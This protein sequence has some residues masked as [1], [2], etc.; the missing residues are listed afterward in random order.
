MGRKGKVQIHTAKEIKGKVQAAK[1][2]NGAAGGGGEGAKNRVEA[3]AKASVPCEVCTQ[4]LPSL[5]TAKI[6]FE[7]KHPKNAFPEAAYA[8]KFQEAKKF[9]EENK[10]VWK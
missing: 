5:N 7:A 3:R 4:I 9:A 6:H 2:R 8:V 10:S 1:E